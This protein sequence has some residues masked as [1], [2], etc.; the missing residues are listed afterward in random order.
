VIALFLAFALMFGAGC[1]SD[2]TPIPGST[3]RVSKPESATGSNRDLQLYIFSDEADCSNAV[4]PEDVGICLPFVDRA[5]GQARISFQ[6]RVADQPWPIPLSEDNFSVLHKN[7]RVTPDGATNDVRIIPH[8]PRHGE[9]MFILLIDTSGSMALDDDGNGRTR[10][11]K[12]KSAL[13]RADVVDAFFPEGINT[14]VVPLVFR[15]GNP[16]PL[17]PKVLV[18]NKKDYRAI[19]KDNLQVGAG[20]THLYNAI[21]YATSTLLALPDIK[22]AIQNK[23]QQPTI[24]ALTDGF[25]DE[26]PKDLCGD[27]APRLEKLLKKLDGLRHGDVDPRYTPTVY[28]VGLGHKAWR[29]FQVPDGTA[30][31][32]AQ[33]CR[34]R[35]GDVIDGNVENEG[36]DNAAL[37]W[38]AKVGGGSSFV[39][40][41]PE[42][43]ADAFKAA[44]AV[45]YG[46]FE[47]RYRLDPFHFRRAFKT[48][49]K[50]SNVFTTQATITI[51]PSGWLD[52]PPGIR[53]ADGWAFPNHFTRTTTLVFPLLGAITAMTY[54]PA[55]LFNVRRMLGS[56]VARRRRR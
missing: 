26:S 49:I 40:P 25:N 35:A 29:R 6:M 24:I 56:R 28:T 47:A 5:T 37:A 52:G 46:W 36:V 18:D 7:Q 32:A 11:D 33:I 38:V 1:A 54:L 22:A 20:Y 42:G 31:S 3:I 9:Q 44:A 14:A 30:V 21:D 48:T 10:M 50:L 4:K 45:R 34:G 39:G 55:A 41:T 8:D 2:L 13:L 12:L 23:Q 53:D 27:N 17:A 43:L 16:T 19:I 51:H 15:D